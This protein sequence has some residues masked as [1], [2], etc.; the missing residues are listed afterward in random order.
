MGEWRELQAAEVPLEAFVQ[1]VGKVN[2][3]ACSY[4]KDPTARYGYDEALGKTILR[5]CASDRAGRL[6]CLSARRA[7]R[8]FFE[9]TGVARPL[10]QLD[11]GQLKRSPAA[12]SSFGPFTCPDE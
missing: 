6:L 10:V 2:E 7:A 3:T 12:A 8:A 4:V 1:V 11:I 9:S 5:D